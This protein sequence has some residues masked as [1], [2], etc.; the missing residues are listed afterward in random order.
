M[1]AVNP[2]KLKFNLF[3]S[4]REESA[5]THQR[6]NFGEQN[7][8]HF[9]QSQNIRP[10]RGDKKEFGDKKSESEWRNSED[11]IQRYNGENFDAW[12]QGNL[13]GNL[14]WLDFG[15]WLKLRDQEDGEEGE[16]EERKLDDEDLFLPLHVQRK[17][18]LQV[19]KFWDV[20]VQKMVPSP[21][22]Q[23][24]NAHMEATHFKKGLA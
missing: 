23:T 22:F 11:T 16:E 18:S 20:L 4:G 17:L 6:S 8:C 5:V 21:S 15:R 2:N 24:G 1:G 19:D 3:N 9:A 10:I 14:G 7:K 12:F 13:E